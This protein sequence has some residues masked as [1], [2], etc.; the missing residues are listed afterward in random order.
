MAADAR[1]KA[2]AVDDVTGVEASHLAVGVELVEVGDT[3]GQVG[4]GEQLDGLGL[5][6]AQHELG[7]AHGAVGVHALELGGVGALREQAGELLGRGDGLGVVLRRAHHDAAG[8]QVVVES[9]ALAQELRAEE[10]LVVTQPL[11]QARGVADGDGRLDD[12]PGVRVHRAHGGD[13]GLDGARVEEVPVRVV[14]SG[15]SDDG[16][17]GARIGLGHVEGGMQVELALPRLGLR[18]EALN[19]IVLDGRLVVVDLLDLLGH[20]VQRVDLVVLREQDGEGQAD[21]AGTGDSDLHVILQ[22]LKSNN[23]H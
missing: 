17:V 10:D 9:L 1:L 4:V 15:R 3:E 12:D 16:V 18:K 2:H 11:A 20:D 23:S 7:D 5:G 6:G 21:I 14:V 22:L 8:V 13:G 19:L